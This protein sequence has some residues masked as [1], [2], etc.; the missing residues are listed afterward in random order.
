MTQSISLADLITKTEDGFMPSDRENLVLDK[1]LSKDQ[2]VLRDEYKNEK[3][4]RSALRIKMFLTPAPSRRFTQRGVVPMRELRTQTDITSSLVNV[5]TDWLLSILSDDEMADSFEQ[6]IESKFNDIFA[7]ADKLARFAQRLEDKR[8]I[9]HRNPSKALNAFGACFW[10]VTPTYA[11][12]GKCNIVRATDDALVLEF[13]PIPEH[14]RC[15]KARS[16]FYKLYP[17]SDEAPVTGMLAL[18]GVAGNQLFMYHGHGHI[19]SIPYHEIGDAIRSFAKKS[20][21]ELD[22]IAKSQLA[23]HCGQKFMTILD[24]IRSKQ[25]IDDIIQTA[26]QSDRKK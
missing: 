6:F 13:E 8:D 14:L 11:I 1:Y 10:A 9:L 4:N 5:V 25:K 23:V 21:D 15:G 19:R 3:N 16:T 22:A 2:K 18:R 20:Q 12:E 17:L 26:K 24:Q 7:S